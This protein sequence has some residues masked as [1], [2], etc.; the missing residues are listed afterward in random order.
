MGKSNF[1]AMKNLAWIGLAGIL[2]ACNEN[3]NKQT[4]TAALD[5]QQIYSEKSPALNNAPLPNEEV[6][7]VSDQPVATY[8]IPEEGFL[9]TTESLENNISR[10][11]S[12]ISLLEAEIQRATSVYSAPQAAEAD[13]QTTDEDIRKKLDEAGNKIAEAKQKLDEARQKHTEGRF[14]AAVENLKDVNKKLAEAEDKYNAV[15][16][17]E[18]NIDPVD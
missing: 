17:K 18:A 4:E 11:S 15:I 12:N 7:R 1:L 14:D 16:E 2:F 10:L 3:E 5:E 8:T 9:P 6:M 13:L